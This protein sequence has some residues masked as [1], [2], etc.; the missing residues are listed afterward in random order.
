MLFRRGPHFVPSTL[1][2]AH[3]CN[4]CSR[5]SNTLLLTSSGT[6]P[7]CDAHTHTCRQTLVYV[8]LILKTTIPSNH[9]LG[10]YDDRSWVSTS[11]TSPVSSRVFL[12]GLVA[13]NSP[14]G[15]ILQGFYDRF[16]AGRYLILMILRDWFYGDPCFVAEETK[17]IEYGWLSQSW[18]ANS[19][20]E[21]ETHAGSLTLMHAGDFCVDSGSGGAFS[22]GVVCLADLFCC[23]IVWFC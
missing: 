14:C 20:A 10:F 21:A 8:F 6:K 1:I 5:R 18:S 15:P 13:V 23:R 4:S 19:R 11:A 17:G 16:P 7:I 9:G 3:N 2:A 12:H 22:S